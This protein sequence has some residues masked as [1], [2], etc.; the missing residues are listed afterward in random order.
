MVY[1][2]YHN[3]SRLVNFGKRI[4][5]RVMMNQSEM[6][7][8]LILSISRVMEE[9]GGVYTCA[10]DRGGQAS[11]VLHV[12]AGKIPGFLLIKSCYTLVC[13]SVCPKKL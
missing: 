13:L 6:S 2:R 7:A 9:D 12:I 1:S 8:T 11:Q 10:P 3:S 4:V 5:D